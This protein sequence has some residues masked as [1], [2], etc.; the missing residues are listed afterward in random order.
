PSGWRVAT[1]VGFK[2]EIIFNSERVRPTS[3]PLKGSA[4]G[5]RFQRSR[6]I[7]SPTPGLSLRS[8]RWAEISERLRRNSTATLLFSVS[9]VTCWYELVNHR[10]AEEAEITQS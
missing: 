2:I 1:T 8:N 6:L 5:E 3:N 10:G 4:V 7:R 9:V